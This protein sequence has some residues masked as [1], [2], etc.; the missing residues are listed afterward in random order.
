MNLIS[1]E[2]RDVKCINGSITCSSKFFEVSEA[3]KVCQDGSDNTRMIRKGFPDVL[4]CIRSLKRAS[5]RLS[6][7]L[8]FGYCQELA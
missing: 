7:L 4:S 2:H 1:K 6:E 3:L 5:S 8:K